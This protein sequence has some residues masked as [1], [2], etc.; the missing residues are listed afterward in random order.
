MTQHRAGVAEGEG[1]GEARRR[2]GTTWPI[3]SVVAAGLLVAACSSS[4]PAVTS[5]A[6]SSTTSVTG[7]PAKPPATPTEAVLLKTL[8]ALA[9]ANATLTIN[10]SKLLTAD[11]AGGPVSMSTLSSIVSA[12]TQLLTTLRAELTTSQTTLPAN[13][14]ATAQALLA[15]DQ[16]ALSAFGQTSSL[17]IGTGTGTGSVLPAGA[18]GLLNN[19]A[20]GPL[21]PQFQDDAAQV[22]TMLSTTGRQLVTALKADVS[23]G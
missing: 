23:T 9:A 12:D 5:A 17:L 15:H 1:E 6:S 7:G 4:G 3:V 18:S 16:S 2:P 22:T 21:V 20:G 19:Y 11:N 13:T 10:L 8:G 14:T